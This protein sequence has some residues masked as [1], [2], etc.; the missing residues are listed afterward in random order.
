MKIVTQNKN[1]YRAVHIEERLEAGIVLS[2][3]EVKSIRAGKVQLADAYVH[4]AGGEAFLLKAHVAEYVAGSW[5]NHAPTRRR[6]LL[7]HR[8]EI[9]R[10]K[11]KI[12]EKGFTVVPLKVYL[13][14]KGLIK[15]ELGIGRGKKLHDRREDMKRRDAERDIRRVFRRGS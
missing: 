11:S 10:I 15:V 1:A 13:N 5:T 4:V 9:G 6:K 7:L 12:D 14:D 8:R 3:T 2:G